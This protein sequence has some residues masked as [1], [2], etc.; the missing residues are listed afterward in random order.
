ME[1]TQSMPVTALSWTTYLCTHGEQ[2]AAKIVRFEYKCMKAV[3][4]FARENNIECDSWEGDT[5]DVIYDEGQLA[6]A[7]IAVNK[8]QNILEKKDHAARYIFWDEEK[9]RKNF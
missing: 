8:I 2:E 1:V 3:H 4:A 7:K 6:R 5:A 9:L